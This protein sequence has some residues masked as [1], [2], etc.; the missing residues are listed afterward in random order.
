MRR[1]SGV[2]GAAL[3][4]LC[5]V[6]C[7]W[8]EAPSP[9]SATAMS[10]PTVASNAVMEVGLASPTPRPSPS[11][12]QTASPTASPSP[13]T[14][15]PTVSQT[16]R[17]EPS[18][19]STPASGVLHTSVPSLN[20]RGGPGVDYAA[21]GSLS[22]GES[23]SYV[24]TSN[25]WYELERGGW[26]SG[27]Y[28]EQG[29]APAVSSDSVASSSTP[30]SSSTPVPTVQSTPTTS[31][32]TVW[33]RTHGGQAEID[34]RSGAVYIDDVAGWLGKPYIAM[35]NSAGAREWT[36][37]NVGETVTL[38]G[39]ISGTYTV[40]AMTWGVQRDEP[41][42]LLSLPGTILLQTCQT[43]GGGNLVVSLV[44]K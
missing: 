31:T 21:N 34:Q 22:A 44:G 30:S 23:V 14:A 12:P 7:A 35:H 2:A 33:I 18:Y 43:E 17:A 9:V 42:K 16:P 29:S 24:A 39:L 37:W 32:H 8:S 25:G 41:S 40:T 4:S 38:T 20:V 6:A 13:Q 5:V 19:V 3:V 1:L 10:S 11:A 27:T 36:T 26:V 28:V 15:S